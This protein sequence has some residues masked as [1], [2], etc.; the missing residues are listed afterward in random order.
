MYCGDIPSFVYEELDH[1][2]VDYCAQYRYGAA[3]L[4]TLDLPDGNQYHLQSHTRHLVY[5]THRKASKRNVSG[6]TTTV[7]PP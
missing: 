7:P 2:A 5:S 1:R 3:M 6:T 4:I